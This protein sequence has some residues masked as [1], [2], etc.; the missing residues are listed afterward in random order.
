[1]KVFE[2]LFSIM[3]CE[4]FASD[5]EKLEDESATK[6][7]GTLLPWLSARIVFFSHNAWPPHRL[8]NQIP[9]AAPVAVLPT[10]VALVYIARD[11]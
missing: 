4:A 8:L 11:G 2:T 5:A 10:I 9:P 3:L 7:F 1:V 6:S